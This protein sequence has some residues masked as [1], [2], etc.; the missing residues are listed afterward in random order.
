MRESRTPID[1]APSSERLPKHIFLKMTGREVLSHAGTVSHRDALTK[2]QAEYEAYHR[3][4]LDDPSPVEEHFI[5][6]VEHAGKL[7]AERSADGRG[8]EE[9]TIGK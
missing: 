3:T 4:H 7:E 5:E 8:P 1:F 6:A 9:R 2:A